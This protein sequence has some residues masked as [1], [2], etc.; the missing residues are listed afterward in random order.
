[1]FLALI[2]SGLIFFSRSNDWIFVRFL[3]SVESLLLSYWR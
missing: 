2:F 1:M 3:L